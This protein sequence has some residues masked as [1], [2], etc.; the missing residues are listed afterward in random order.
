MWEQLVS[1]PNLSKFLLSWPLHW[2]NLFLV[3]IFKRNFCEN[4]SNVTSVELKRIFSMTFLFVEKKKILI[5]SEGINIKNKARQLKVSS[6]T[7]LLYSPFLKLPINM[8]MSS[9]ITNHL[10]KFLLGF[11]NRKSRRGGL[12]IFRKEIFSFLNILIIF[13]NSSHPF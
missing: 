5:Y 10:K 2:D 6:N 1:F 11:K 7:K 4:L 3:K 13:S 9:T 8:L 12:Q